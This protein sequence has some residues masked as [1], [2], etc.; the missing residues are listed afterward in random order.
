MDKATLI[1]NITAFGLV[2]AAIAI[3]GAA[4]AF[5]DVPSLLIVV[6]GTI[7]AALISLPLPQFTGAMAVA[8]N[9]FF[10]KTKNPAE[11]VG[12]M[13]EY[14]GKARKEGILALESA[15][16]EQ[17]DPFLQKALQ[18]AVDGQSLN[19]IEE[20][21]TTEIEAIKQRHSLGAETFTTMGT[22][23]PA[24]GLIG[25]LIGLVQ[26]LKSMD[27][28]ST[29]GPAM[30]VAL[31]TTFYGAILANLVF[32]PIAAKLKTRSKEEVLYKELIL[33]GMLS[34]AAG[35]NPRI[36]EQKLLSYLAPRQRASQFAEA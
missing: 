33:T 20:I 15:A 8:K 29:I 3:G 32:N 12:T 5:I 7:G 4:G 16:K 36:V 27:D 30:A 21:L 35:D 18:L 1:G 13:V 31:L 25:T 22:L 9:A 2:I 24:L 19:A 26:M 17:Q 28:P 14:A 34:I 11:L 10:E 23:A 6:G